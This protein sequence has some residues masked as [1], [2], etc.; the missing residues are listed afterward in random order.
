MSTSLTA[1]SLPPPLVPLSATKH[2]GNMPMPPLPA[3][4]PRSLMSGSNLSRMRDPEPSMRDDSSQVDVSVIFAASVSG[5]R[6]PTT[7][8]SSCS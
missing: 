1:N 5:Q 2:P 8:M 6:R 4:A 3:G 7:R